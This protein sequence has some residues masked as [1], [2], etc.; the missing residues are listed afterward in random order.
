MALQFPF[1]FSQ[2]M[3][4]S[5][6]A[7]DES[8][9]PP[10]KGGWK[11]WQL[12]LA[13]MLLVLLIVVVVV[14]VVVASA[15]GS[16]PGDSSP[17]S[18]P[19]TSP[20]FPPGQAPPPPPPP[21][22]SENHPQVY[23]FPVK[24]KHLSAAPKPDFYVSPDVSS[25]GL[26]DVH[27][28]HGALLAD[29]GYAVVGKAVEAEDSEL[30][31]AFCIKF[32]STGNVDWV[33]SFASDGKQDAANAVLELP[34]DGSPR[35]LIVVGYKTSGES[36]TFQ[37][38]ITKLDSSTGQEAWTAA[39]PSS[40]TSDRQGA[41]EMASLT[42]D[43]SSVLLAGL[44]EGLDKDEFNFKSYGNVVSGKAI[45]QKLPV[46]ALR[47]A[48]PPSLSDV[49][50]TFTDASFLTCKAARGLAD[51][52]VLLLLYA[53]EATATVTKLLWIKL[54]LCQK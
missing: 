27:P 3:Y 33:W 16:E 18:N 14:V 2:T 41:W 13:I 21:P 20:P 8:K 28:V 17:T 40:E 12:A 54:I 31:K 1:S 29:G 37:R 9:T 50:G 4:K 47:A 38:T 24:S 7:A 42:A 32:S 23:N 53:E 49:T 43:G 36:N 10:K 30:K 44:H 34:D 45:V 52:S 25:H 51:G 19:P 48:T 39:W 22:P 6:G 26:Y 46:S 15:S 5:V 35:A 11:T